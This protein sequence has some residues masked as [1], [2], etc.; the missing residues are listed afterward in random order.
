MTKHK[1]VSLCSDKLLASYTRGAHRNM[2]SLS[3]NMVIVCH[4]CDVLTKFCKTFH[5]QIS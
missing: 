2:L 1:N 3:V 5:F 4:N